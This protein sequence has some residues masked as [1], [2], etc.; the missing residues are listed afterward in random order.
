M[1]RGKT[2]DWKTFM[3]MRSKRMGRTATS[4]YVDFV[5]SL[6]PGEVRAF[7]DYAK[8]ASMDSVRS[9]I[10]SAAKRSGMKVLTTL[11]DDGPL[12]VGRPP[13]QAQAA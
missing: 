1:A 12:L 5:K 6:D 8:D 2:L 11:D 13:T 7:T 4:K 3:D 9:S 10:L